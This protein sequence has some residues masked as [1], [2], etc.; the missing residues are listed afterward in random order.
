MAETIPGQIESISS[1]A[2]RL[3]A[4]QSGAGAGKLTLSSGSGETTLLGSSGGD[5]RLGSIGNITFVQSQLMS[6]DNGTAADPVYSFELDKNTGMYRSAADTLAFTVG[7]QQVLRLTAPSADRS[8]WWFSAETN[9]SILYDHI[10]EQFSILIDA[11]TE[12]FLTSTIFRVPNVFNNTTASAANVFV[13]SAGTLFRDNSSAARYKSNIVPF[14]GFGILD[15]IPQEYDY[16]PEQLGNLK[17]G[18]KRKRPTKTGDLQ[19]TVGFILEEV[20]EAYP[21]AVTYDLKGDPDGLNWKAITTGLVA[22]VRRQRDRLDV[23]EA[24]A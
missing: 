17:S 12:L 20:A 23:L 9:D 2:L 8:Q 19:H 21:I 16:Q 22:E 6:V 18:G 10:T 13:D 4:P 1:M 11:T 5:L 15:L 24:A 14:D 3:A 7:G